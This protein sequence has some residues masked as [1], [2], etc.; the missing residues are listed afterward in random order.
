MDGVPEDQVVAYLDEALRL[1]VE[2]DNMAR[3]VISE[4][5][6]VIVMGG[7]VRLRPGVIQH[8]SIVV[9]IAETPE[10]SQPAAFSQGVTTE[11]PRTTLDVVEGDA[12]LVLMG[13]AT[14][15]EEVVEV[16]NVLGAS[17]RDMIA[18]ME[19]L[20]SSGLLVAELKRM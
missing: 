14:K 1:E 9:T 19:S 12:P 13:G 17:P 16:L 15:L 4:R 7:D 6:G 18:I 3:V 5:T 2:T 11:V 10:V 8:N 20:I